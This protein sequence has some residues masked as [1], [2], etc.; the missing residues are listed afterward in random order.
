MGRPMNLIAAARYSIALIGGCIAIWHCSIVPLRYE[1]ALQRLEAATLAAVN[2]QESQSRILARRTRERVRKYTRRFPDDVRLAMIEG[3][4]ER[5]LGQPSAAV[6]AYERALRYDRRPEIYLNLALAQEEAGRRDEAAR[7]LAS[8]LRFAPEMAIDVPDE[9]LKRQAIAIIR[10][11][12]TAERFCCAAD[13]DGDGAVELL[14]RTS[15]GAVTLPRRLRIAV[16]QRWSPHFAWNDGSGA[17]LIVR[18]DTNGAAELMRLSKNG[19]PLYRQPLPAIGEGWHIAGVG[20][21]TGPGTMSLLL[22][23]MLTADAKLWKFDSNGQVTEILTPSLIVPN[24]YIAACA[25]FSR[26]LEVDAVYRSF[27]GTDFIWLLDDTTRVPQ[28]QYLLP[29]GFHRELIAATDL[30][31]DSHAD[32][33]WYDFENGRML[34][35]VMNEMVVQRVEYWPRR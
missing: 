1:V 10:R 22:S 11:N 3:V 12:Q 9:H 2:M 28:L 16:R 18:H 27:A 7:N 25:R 5:I 32:L 26:D 24:A 15:E 34:L 20:E 14:E 21:F 30:T 35:W 23:N 33:L 29:S 4:N 31:G 8:A 17:N 19:T 13:Y 6:T